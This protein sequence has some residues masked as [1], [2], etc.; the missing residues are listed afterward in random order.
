MPKLLLATLLLVPMLGMGQEVRLPSEVSAVPGQWIVVAPEI[1]SGG[2]AKFRLDAGLE[3]V[4]LDI[5]FPPDVAIQARGKVLS[6]SKPGLYKVE[7]W[8]AK[9]DVPSDIA[10]CWVHVLGTPPE[11]DPAPTPKPK[12]DVVTPPPVVAGP[13]TVLIVRES[14]TDSPSD[15]RMF[16]SLQAGQA[17]QYLKSKGHSAY[18]LDDDDPLG[19]K[20]V[21][22]LGIALPAAAI[23]DDKGVVVFKFSLAN[24]A[25]ADELLAVLK[26]KGG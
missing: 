12:P 1:V 24:G 26:S 4:R 3:E 9:G 25:T 14:A 13:R 5:L 16:A 22:A 2:K 10:T 17:H 21:A 19:A 8:N 20:W 15:A 23:L 18:V 6:A 11:V 7:C